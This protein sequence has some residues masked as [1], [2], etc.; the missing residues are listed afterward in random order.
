VKFVK[1]IQ[2]HTSFI[3][4]FVGVLAFLNL[5]FIILFNPLYRDILYVNTPYILTITFLSLA[6]VIVLKRLHWYP[7][8]APLFAWTGL[9]L[10]MGYYYSLTNMP[11]VVR[12]IID[13]LT[14]KIT[15]QSAYTTFFGVMTVTGIFAFYYFLMAFISG[16]KE[17]LFSQRVDPKSYLIWTL[18]YIIYLNTIVSIINPIFRHPS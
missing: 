6:P 3:I 16:K 11:N 1:F 12:F 15:V 4:T 18:A 17:N 2:G 9:F 13:L 8:A 5:L 10:F 7:E 14:M